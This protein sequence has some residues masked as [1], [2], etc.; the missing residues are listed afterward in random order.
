MR[1]PPPELDQSWRG[2]LMPCRTRLRMP[3][4]RAALDSAP[5]LISHR[6]DNMYRTYDHRAPRSG[7]DMGSSEGA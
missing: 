1:H 4:A 6:V 3:V 2:C 5:I 7:R